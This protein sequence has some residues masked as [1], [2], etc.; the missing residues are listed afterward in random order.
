MSQE[1]VQPYARK[2]WVLAAVCLAL[3]MA[4]LDGTVVNVSIPAISKG[5]GATFSQIEWV[6]NAYTLVFASMLVTFGR[7]GDMFGRKRFFVA[8]LVLFGLGS[9]ACGLSSTPAL[10]IASRFVQAL[11][12]A[13][14]MP[15]TLSLTA[16]NFPPE[17][18]GMAMGIWGAVSGVA[19]AVGPVLGGWL[20]DAFSW[21]AI[22]FI[23]LPIVL[24]A[25]PFALWAIPESRDEHPHAIDWVGAFLSMGLL[26]SLC[27]GLIE[28]PKLGWTDPQILGLFAAAAVLLALFLAWERRAKEPIIDLRLFR[29]A[30]FSAGNAAGAVLMFGMMGIFFLLP[31]YLQAQAG[32]TAIQTGLAL[33]P[34]SAAILVAAPAAGRLSDRIGSRWLVFAGM[35]IAAA[36]GLW[37]SFLPV[38]AGW[39]W[40][41]PPLAT[42][43][44]GMGLVMAP[45]TSA[46]MAT[47]PAGEE[48][49]ASGVLSTMRQV[50]GV[51]GVAVL[52]AVFSTAMT[53]GMLAHVPKIPGLPSE[54]VPYVKTLV[55]GR[56]GGMGTGAMDLEALRKAVP[57][58]ALLPLID[59]AVREAAAETL[60]EPARDRVA[61]AV[62]EQ[63]AKGVSLEGTA[64]MSAL[65]P[66][67]EE[68]AKDGV[69]VDGQAFM[70]FGM[71]VGAKVKAKFEALGNGFADAAT[72]AFVEAVRRAMRVAAATLAAGAILALLMRPR[73]DAAALEAL[74]A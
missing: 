27:Y 53:A 23:N 31:I 37:L 43:G 15:A 65:A 20:T 63:V 3:F 55:E 46:V 33:T 66:L 8:G 28:G 45:L 50:G 2:W 21:H 38:G 4:L 16:V 13:L 67:A 35:L 6:L 62:I 32:Y 51:F 9:L 5:L 25:V 34:L 71:T 40:L 52:G 19:S 12:G 59:S 41:L 74:H 29:S 47:A 64:M 11:G 61:D 49:A 57:T 36:A 44:V 30:A 10:L 26:A 17:E 24:L 14:M 22:F 56:S 39:R 68:L 1:S 58:Q 54:A 70:R 73:N 48:G 18:R 42:A 72:Q 7:L 60:P 69:A